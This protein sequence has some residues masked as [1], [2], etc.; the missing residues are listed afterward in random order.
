MI[1]GGL[2]KKRLFL[3]RAAKA[4]RWNTYGYLLWRLIVWRA[5]NGHPGALFPRKLILT[6]A[7]VRIPITAHLTLR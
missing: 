6:T 4:N 5:G 7:N 3:G 1:L 2:S